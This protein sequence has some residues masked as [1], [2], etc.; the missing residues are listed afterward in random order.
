MKA[1]MQLTIEFDAPHP[2]QEI[3]GTSTEELVA[4]IADLLADSGRQARVVAYN[5]FA[6]V[7]TPRAAKKKKPTRKK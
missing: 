2:A 4:A 7:P 6:D 3:G 5:V 1:L